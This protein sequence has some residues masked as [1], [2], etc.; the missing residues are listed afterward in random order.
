MSHS[1]G[2]SSTNEEEFSSIP[3]FSRAVSFPSSSCTSGF[4]PSIVDDV[5]TAI[6]SLHPTIMDDVETST[7]SE[8]P[9]FYAP[10]QTSVN[11]NQ[12]QVQLV[13]VVVKK[14]EPSSSVHLANE[15]PS[16]G[17]E[18]K[19]SVFSCTQAVFFFFFGP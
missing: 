10:Q 13:K 8:K 18:S 4:H 6:S 16:D 17:H 14:A 3:S 2:A 9:S 15:T 7:S 1:Q 19:C 11:A 5:E 12:S